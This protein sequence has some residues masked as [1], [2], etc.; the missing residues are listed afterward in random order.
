MFFMGDTTAS[1]AEEVSVTHKLLLGLLSLLAKVKFDL[2]YVVEVLH[3]DLVPL[4]TSFHMITQFFQVTDLSAELAFG[5]WVIAL[6][7]VVANL[8]VLTNLSPATFAEYFHKEAFV[9]FVRA[10]Y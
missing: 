9:K 6:D 2:F 10:E 3:F 4:F 5:Y 7:C 8:L 1:F